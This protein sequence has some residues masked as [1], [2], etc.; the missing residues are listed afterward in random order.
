MGKK[1]SG[2]IICFL[3]LLA[4]PFHAFAANQV[5]TVDIQAV[6]YEDGSMGIT[7][8]W[9]GSFNEGTESYIP[10]N[11]PDYLTISELTVS[12]QDGSYDTVPDWN[13]HW[14]FEEK[15]RKC[16]IYNTGKDVGN[17]YGYRGRAVRPYYFQ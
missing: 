11:A 6:I 16:D 2:L 9:E 14:S 3:L 8:I 1:V 4:L 17:R 7:Q 13:I 12:D 15:A 10:M 5:D